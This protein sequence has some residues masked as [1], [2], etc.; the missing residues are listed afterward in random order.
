MNIQ[1]LY[2]DWV[3][4]DWRPGQIWYRLTC[5]AWHR[6][7]TVKP[8]Y[9]GHTW[10]DRTELMPNMMFEIL[11]QFVEKEC[12]PGHV[13]WGDQ[14]ACNQITIDGIEKNAMD[15]MKELIRWW[16]EDYHKIYP[17][18]GDMLWAEASKHS[19]TREFIDVPDTDYIEWLPEFATEE[20]KTIYN[21]CLMATNKL[22]RNMDKALEDRLHRIVNLIPYL[23]T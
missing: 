12:S 15:E 5:W 8:R 16:H 11:C 23:W 21:N 6:H 3:P 14:W 10:C 19:P 20:D 4:Y 7:T 18:V 1:E 22:E 13:E 9:L 2:W 17:E